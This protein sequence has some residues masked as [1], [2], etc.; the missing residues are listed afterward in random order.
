MPLIIPKQI[1]AFKLLKDFVFLM[2][3]KRARSQDIRPLEVAIF[4]LM[5]T[6]IETENQLLSL[7]GNSPLQ[8]NVT[9]LHTKSYEGKNTPKSHLDRFYVDFEQIKGRKF[10]AAIVTG[11]PIEHLDYEEVK[12]WHELK[13]I[14]SYLKKHTTSTLYLCWGAMA[15]LYHFHK[16]PKKKLK[17]KL[18][19]VFKH[20][21]QNEDLLLSGLDEEILLPH[22][23]HSGLDEKALKACKSLKVLLFGKKSGASVLKDE[24]DLFIL[25]HPEYTKFTLFDE[26]QRDL[27]KGEKIKKP[28]NYFDQK[29]EPVIKWRAN[30]QVLFSNWLNFV[31]QETPFSLG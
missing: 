19:G 24:K 3:D 26:Y 30:A 25:A 15:A 29:G 27:K 28:K 14:M 20:K 4:N 6:K 13:G 5:P 18:F 17:N 23:R 22:S 2:D 11:A 10:D 9:F 21:I 12:Y 7:I 1:P 16:I 31:Y 8:V